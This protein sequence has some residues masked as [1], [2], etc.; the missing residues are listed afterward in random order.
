M[1]VD[2]AALLVAVT[3]VDQMVDCGCCCSLAAEINERRR[4]PTT[5]SSED[6]A[7]DSCRRDTRLR[8]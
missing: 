5:R 8:H 1:S 4:R 6:I 3:L 7:I 2:V